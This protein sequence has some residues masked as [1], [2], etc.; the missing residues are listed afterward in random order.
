MAKLSSTINVKSGIGCRYAKI[1]TTRASWVVLELLA[2]A[3]PELDVS[4]LPQLVK[5][6]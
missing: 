6:K 3:I 1:A 5:V 4:P 2:S